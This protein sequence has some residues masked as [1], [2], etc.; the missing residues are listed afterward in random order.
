MPYIVYPHASD[1]LI[2]VAV[3][4]FLH[5]TLSGDGGNTLIKAKQKNPNCNA[6]ARTKKQVMNKGNPA[7]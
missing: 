5:K 2:T 4:F 1:V 3:F 6:R 7:W